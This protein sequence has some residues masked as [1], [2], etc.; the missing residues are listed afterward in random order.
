[1]VIPVYNGAQ[2]LAEAIG[3]IYAQT[4][5]PDE[6]IVINDGSTDD[7]E[8]LLRRLEADLPPTFRW[9]S[10]EHRGEAS[11]RNLGVKLASGAF[12][13]FL[14]HD[15]KWYPTK[16]ARQIEHFASEPTLSLSFTGYVRTTGATAGAV[17]HEEWNADPTAVLRKL[18]R[19]CAVGPPS[20]VLIRRETLSRVPPFDESLAVF[21]CDWLMWLRI[22]AAGLKIGYLSDP[23]AEYRWHGNNRSRSETRYYESACAVFDRFFATD[24]RPVAVE[25][26]NRGARW[27]R[28]RWHMLAAINAVQ[29]GDKRVARRHIVTATRLHPASIRPGWARMLGAGPARR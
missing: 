23:L 22:A 26:R 20:A 13:A 4:T 19:S 25:G 28:A 18:M 3:S 15:D 14:D 16:L 5:V 24:G 27:W 12:V 11:A 9:V 21:G 10:A 1:V 7:T 29:R 8:G 6:V 17:Q 2:S